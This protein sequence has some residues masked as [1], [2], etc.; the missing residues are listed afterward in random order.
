MRDLLVTAQRLNKQSAAI[1]K[2]SK[3]LQQA[4]FFQPVTDHVLDFDSNII[5]WRLPDPLIYRHPLCRPSK[6]KSRYKKA[7]EYSN[8]SW[9]RQLLTQPPL[10]S[11]EYFICSI[12]PLLHAVAKNASGV[13]LAD[14]RLSRP[15]TT[16]EEK[17]ML[18]AL[19]QYLDN[20]AASYAQIAAVKSKVYNGPWKAITPTPGN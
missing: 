10:T 12:R 14:V 20:T 5:D 2:S 1:T 16:G 8:A 11:V 19:W 17:Y 4:L 6:A 7:A 9:R 15:G 13:R 18:G 3:K